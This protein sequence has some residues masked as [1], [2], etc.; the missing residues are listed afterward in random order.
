MVHDTS[1]EEWSKGSRRKGGGGHD[2][3]THPCRRSPPT[4]PKDVH[5]DLLLSSAMLSQMSTP[6]QRHCGLIVTL[7]RWMLEGSES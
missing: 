3:L 7:G 4:C 5:A 1:Q 2:G 6:S